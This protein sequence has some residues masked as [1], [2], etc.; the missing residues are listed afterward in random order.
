MINVLD[1]SNVKILMYNISGNTFSSLSA[2]EFYYVNMYTKSENRF[3]KF[4][5]SRCLVIERC[6]VK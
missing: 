2:F 6:F 5:R 3:V 1:R 4:Q